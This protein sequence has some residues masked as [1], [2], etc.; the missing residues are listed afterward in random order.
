MRGTPSVPP[1]S[2]PREGARAARRG[3]TRLL[4][5]AL[6]SALACAAAAPRGYRFAGTGA[7]W[8]DDGATDIDDLTE[9]YPFYFAI[10]FDP[11][12]TRD[13]DLR[14]LR[15]DIERDP[16]DVFNF[17]ALNAIAVGYFELSYRAGRTGSASPPDDFRAAKLLAVPWKAYTTTDDAAL[18]DAILDF[19][20]D[21]GSGRKRGTAVSAPRIARIVASLAAKERDPGRRARILALTDALEVES[22]SEWRE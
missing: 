10:L 19:F 17:D 3:G 18:R 2:S 15:H 20:A 12:S 6:L 11:A 8:N 4:A 21:A 16:V 1:P 5:L 7:Y 22:S 13:P 9:R 14:P